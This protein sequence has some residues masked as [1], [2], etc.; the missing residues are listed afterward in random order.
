MA[1]PKR[2]A[3]TIELIGV[4]HPGLGD[5]YHGLIRAPW[6]ATLALI[7]AAYL[8]INLAFAC[9][10]AITGGIDGARGFLDLFFFSVETSGTIGYGALHPVT[11]AAHLVVTVESIVSILLV[12]LTTGLVFAKF[13]IP[14][15]RVR[16]ATNPTIAPY[17]GVPTLYIR[18]GNQRDSRLIDATLRVVL[19]RT[20]RTK[21]GV[22]MYRMYDLVLERERSP[23]MS[24]SW[25]ALHRI[26]EGSP[27]HGSTPESLASQEAELM[28][29]VIGMDEISV[30][31]HHAQHLYEAKDLRWGMRPGDMVSELP[32]GRLRVD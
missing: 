32:D 25:I 6:S 15:A 3:D 26:V 17:D 30:Q 11:T 5:L 1:R 29:T 16:F 31:S 20:E 28:L 24:R 14:R 21:E 4:G 10:F 22:T 13:S 19:M 18:L 9:A 23:A 12:A 27:L 2:I 7:V 8:I